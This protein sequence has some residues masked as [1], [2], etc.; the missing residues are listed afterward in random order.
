MYIHIYTLT[1]TEKPFYQANTVRLAQQYGIYKRF[2]HFCDSALKLGS[3]VHLV[4]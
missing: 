3:C 1:T 2:S 4:I